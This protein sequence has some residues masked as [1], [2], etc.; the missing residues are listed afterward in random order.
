MVYPF[1]LNVLHSILTKIVQKKHQS[2][3]TGASITIYL[4]KR[5]FPIVT[6]TSRVKIQSLLAVFELKK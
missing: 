2:I 4:A 1:C 5:W 6:V 3:K